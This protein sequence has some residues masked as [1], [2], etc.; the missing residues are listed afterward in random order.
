MIE[1]LARALT[2]RP[3]LVLMVA[4]ILLVP[5][6]INFLLTPV[7][8]DILSYLPANTDSARG[9]KILE[10]PFHMAATC[11][12]VVDEMPPAF[13]NELAEKIQKIDGVSSAVWL[14]NL[15]GIQIPT[16]FLPTEIQNMFYSDK[17]TMMLIQFD[18]P[19]ADQRTRNALAE[20]QSLCNEK[21]FTSGFSV[22]MKDIR[23]SMD[24]EMPYYILMAAVLSMVAM[25]LTMESPILPIVLMANIGLAIIYNFGT[26][27]VLGEISYITKAIAAVLQLGVTMDYSIFLYRRFEEEKAKYED[28]R[29]AMQKAVEA[30]FASLFGSSLT[31]V[32]GFIALCFM[33]FTLGLDL[34]VVMAKGVLLGIVTVITVLPSALL[35]TER[36]LD[37]G[38]HRSLLPDLSKLSG[39]CIR[40]RRV[41][42]A[43]AI[44]LFLPAIYS[45]SHAKVYYAVH[46]SLPETLPSIVG[47]RKLSD[48]FD[49][50]NAHYALVSDEIPSTKMNAMEQ[51][52]AEVDGVTSVLS[53]HSL[54]G[55]GIPD[56]FMPD[57]LRHMLKAGGYQLIMINSEYETASDEIARQ[58]VEL[59]GILKEFDESA[60]LTGEP[61]M[62]EDLIVT[63][64][65]DFKTTNYISILC[66][67]VII[68]ILF[69]SI[70]VPV[71]LVG[72]IELAICINQGISYYT[73]TAVPFIAP[74]VISCVQLGATVDYAILLASR[75]REELRHGHGRLEAAQLATNSSCS[76]IITSALVMF[77]ATLGVSFVSTMDL[78]SGICTTL[79]RGAIISAIL[80]I[81]FL[82]ALLTLFEPLFRR[83]SYGW[84]S[85]P[86]PAATADGAPALLPEP[87]AETERAEESAPQEQKRV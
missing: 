16:E 46:D 38:K 3:K 31:T 54:L 28:H 8:Y 10:D 11:M 1:K 23:D 63:T 50:A 39:F 21:C 80:S 61:A 70:S 66:I 26:N 12:L 42:A 40:H 84:L 62:T 85:G 76:S 9:E 56:F 83:T 43:I 47:M 35:L 25:A 13:T 33:R 34:G 45:E 69:R 53:Y 17:G 77:M 57:A 81:F 32:A 52:I 2:R 87:E 37:K 51:R 78:V 7:N 15:L 68:A 24:R 60:L 75:F 29:D 73:G 41:L 58:C 4:L 44:V 65:E 64:A 20:I 18:N 27:F 36:W 30:A 22:L 6:V 5:A 79:A 82:P 59:Q 86:A 72:L 55:T 14:S 71:V 48:D 49:M 67:F 74:T 19:A